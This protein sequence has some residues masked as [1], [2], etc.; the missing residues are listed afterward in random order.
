[1]PL[2]TRASMGGQ[3]PADLYYPQ[4]IEMQ[5]EVV[6]ER[7]LGRGR[8]RLLRMG[9]LSYAELHSDDGAFLNLNELRQRH[10]LAF[11]LAGLR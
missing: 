4:W 5:T 6:Q 2:G 10:L 11:V 1:M 3:V 7:V 9:G 8:A